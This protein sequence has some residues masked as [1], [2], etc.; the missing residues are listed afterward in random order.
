MIGAFAEYM[1]IGVAAAPKNYTGAALTETY[2]SCK[3]FSQVAIILQTGAWAGGT[4][5]VTLTQASAVAGTGAKALA[6]AEMYTNSGA[7]TSS[8]LTKTTVTSNTFNLSAAGVMYCI[9]VDVNNL[10]IAN[11]FDC[12]ALSVATPG[13]NADY[14]SAVYVGVNGRYNPPI[15]ILVD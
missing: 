7:T 4:A 5:A 13:A 2:V 12:L 6:F 10:D 11:G 9:C 1:P 14:Y 8:V 15:N 3:S